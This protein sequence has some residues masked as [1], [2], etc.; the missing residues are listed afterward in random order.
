MGKCSVHTEIK[1]NTSISTLSQSS[2]FLQLLVSQVFGW[3]S[4]VH[5]LPGPSSQTILPSKMVPEVSSSQQIA[6]HLGLWGFLSSLMI[7]FWISF[8][9]VLLSLSL[10]MK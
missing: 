9:L 3:S 5:T 8:L 2:L 4:N 1:T 7:L 10:W 6:L